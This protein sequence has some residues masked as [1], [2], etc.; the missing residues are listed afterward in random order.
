MRR[1]ANKLLQRS[2][3]SSKYLI[4][5]ISV[6]QLAILVGLVIWNFQDPRL[7]SLGL[8]QAFRSDGELSTVSILILRTL[9]AV[10]AVLLTF[11]F[12][13]FLWAT[14]RVRSLTLA[15]LVLT[16]F[17]GDLA[18]ITSWQRVSW[19]GRKS[20]IQPA[21]SE[22]NVIAERLLTSWPRKDDKDTSFGPF[23]AYPAYDPSILI[24]LTP[25]RVAD[26]TYISSIERTGAQII[27]FE[28][29]DGQHS[30]WIELHKDGSIPE[31]FTSGLGDESTVVREI[32]VDR[33]WYLVRYQPSHHATESQ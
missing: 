3:W 4:V 5:V 1:L 10:S 27:R 16:I 2:T 33:D 31:E 32:H 28:L 9:Y 29:S 20:R 15:A 14:A 7:E 11:Q 24:L 22:L 8:L 23:M 30:I 18:A 26:G 6:I 19:A 17:A 21:L 25:H 13:T 12:S